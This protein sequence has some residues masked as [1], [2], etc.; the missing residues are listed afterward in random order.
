[1]FW[2]EYLVV[3]YCFYMFDYVYAGL[4]DKGFFKNVFSLPTFIKFSS[5]LFWDSVSNLTYFL[6][7]LFKNY[8][9]ILCYLL[10]LPS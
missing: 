3:S 4:V 8:K 5:W 6:E 10:P 1:M 7:F 9:F 2:R